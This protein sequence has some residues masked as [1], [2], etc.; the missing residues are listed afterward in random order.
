MGLR[1]QAGALPTNC[2]LLLSRRLVLHNN[3]DLSSL[4]CE[5]EAKS[6]LSPSDT[7]ATMREHLNTFCFWV[8]FQPFHEGSL[9]WQ[10]YLVVPEALLCPARMQ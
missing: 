2:W 1:S 7:S 10:K 5:T 4:P 3:A 9:W 8:C 6:H